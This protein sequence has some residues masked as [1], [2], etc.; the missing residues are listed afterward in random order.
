MTQLF[1]SRSRSN[2]SDLLNFCRLSSK[3]FE[4]IISLIGPKIKK[5][6][7]YFRECIPVNESF[8]VTLRFLA[9]EDSYTSLM[10]T[11]KISKQCISNIVTEVCQALVDD[12]EDKKEAI[13][14]FISHMIKDICG[15]P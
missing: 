14:L 12:N 5:K 8:T 10:Y 13:L 4:L 11:F 1:E 15:I 6:N 7:T 9:T 3:D 2:E